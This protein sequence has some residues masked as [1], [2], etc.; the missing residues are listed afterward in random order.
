MVRIEVTFA[1]LLRITCGA[2]T[3][4]NVHTAMLATS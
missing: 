1:S 4:G 2:K 3:V